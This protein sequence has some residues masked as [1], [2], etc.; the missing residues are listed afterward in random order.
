M[1]R[2][3]PAFKRTSN[4]QFGWACQATRA[5]V[6]FDQVST[7]VLVAGDADIE[8]RAIG[9]THANL[10]R[11]IG[12]LTLHPWVIDTTVAFGSTNIVANMDVHWIILA[13]D[14]DDDPSQYAPDNPTVLSEERILSHG[15]LGV[16]MYRHA[17]GANND[18]PSWNIIGET[19][20][21]IDVRSNRRIRSDD[22]VVL[23]LIARGTTPEEGFFEDHGYTTLFRALVQFPG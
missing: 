14:N 1:A 11:I 21:H 2:R 22:N 3:R 4:K 16:T 23:N 17:G 6:A 12:D 15:S 7:E 20:A 13:I 10:K 18:T 8:V 5:F 19:K 9:G